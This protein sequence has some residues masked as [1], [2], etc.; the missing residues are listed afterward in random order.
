MTNSIEQRLAWP[1]KPVDVVMDTDT[2]NEIDDQF[3]LSY[4]IQSS[5]QCHLKAIYAVPFYNRKS[6]SPKDGMHK[7]YDEILHLLE[8]MQRTDL[9]NIVYHGSDRYLDAAQKPIDS[10]AAQNLV[11]LARH[12]SPASR[13]T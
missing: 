6:T 10:P 9:K 12:Y 5:D 1:Q 7:S 8:L 3:A 13:C 11:E 2:F 4:L